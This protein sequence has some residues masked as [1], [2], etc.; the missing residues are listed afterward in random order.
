M[1]SVIVLLLLLSG[2]GTQTMLAQPIPTLFQSLT[3]EQACLVAARENK[4]VLVEAGPV[5][6]GVEKGFQGHRELINY[7]MRNVIAIRID[8]STPEGK[9]FESRLQL[10]PY[11]A[12]AY[13]MPYGDL[14]GIVSPEEVRRQPEALREKLLVAQE[15]AKVKKNNSRSVVFA[16]L[17]LQQA[18]TSAGQSGKN[19]F[20]YLYADH[21]QPSLLVEKNVL[22]LDRVADYYNQNFVSLRFRMDQAPVFSEKY[23]MKGSPAYLFLTASGKLLFQA[24]GYGDPEQ[25]ITYGKKALEKAKGVSFESLSDE[26]A[27]DRARQTG[28]LVF[29]DYY[30]PGTVHKEL[31]RTVFADPEVTDLFM[32]NFINVS[33]EGDQVQLVFSDAS[34][35]EL[36]RV[37]R[38]K[39]AADLLCEARRVLAGKG[40][41]GMEEEYRQGNRK[42]EFMEAYI[43]MLYRA[44]KTLEASRLTMEYLSP[45]SPECLKETK[46]WN[47]FYQYGNQA[48]SDFFEYI[49]SHRTELFGRYGEDRVRKKIIDLWTAGAE[50]F[51]R[52]GKF[53]ETGFKEYTKRLKKEKVEG[54]RQIT[55]NARMNAAESLGDWKT[56]ITLAEEKWNEEQIADSELYRWG[57]KINEQCRDE[58]I[59]YKTAQWLAEKALEIERKEQLTGKVK[60]SS[61]KG[62]FAK[63]V[64]DLLKG[65]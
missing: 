26:Q 53:D 9:A 59:R 47:F 21:D 48:T 10:Y 5:E 18:L 33:R 4:L 27:H 60:M 13:F 8:M 50:N 22:N 32:E 61:Y 16:D 64:D 28:K 41:L 63:L 38:V 58:N 42:A 14:V 25:L 12:Y 36:H 20:V 23:Q 55:R 34:G 24:D 2:W 40:L 35:K 29:T 6:K 19:I 30:A 37:V 15:A 11:P 57:V 51:V 52:E 39:D 7:M 1:R 62:F 31:L 17:E 46:Y 44:D 43:E 54:W 65:N 3:W 56:F 49:L 45:L